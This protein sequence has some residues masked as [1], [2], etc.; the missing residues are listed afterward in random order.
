MSIDRFLEAADLTSVHTFLTIAGALL[1]LF[2]MNQTSHL[3]EDKDDPFVV[4]WGNRISMGG[5]ALALLWSLSYSQTKNWQPWP[6]ELALIVGV[7]AW[8]A[9]RA[10]AIH[11]HLR[12]EGTARQMMLRAGAKVARTRN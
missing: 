2:V 3:D 5:I 1:A 8:L 9:F 7:I 10:L 4:R 12:R 6:P 11:F